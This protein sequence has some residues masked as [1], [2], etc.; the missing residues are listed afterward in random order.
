MQNDQSINANADFN[1]YNDSTERTEAIKEYIDSTAPKGTGV[2]FAYSRISLMTFIILAIVSLIFSIFITSIGNIIIFLIFIILFVASY[3][4]MGNSG[5]N[6]Y[7]YLFI[8]TAPPVIGIL[9]IFIPFGGMSIITGFL[10]I[11]I[12]YWILDDRNMIN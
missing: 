1:Q 8:F 10:G 3:M 11:I 7:S 9:A 12:S 2:K 6:A 4:K 5:A